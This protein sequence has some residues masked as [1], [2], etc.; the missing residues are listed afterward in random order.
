MILTTIRSNMEHV[1]N[2]FLKK[3]KTTDAKTSEVGKNFQTEPFC[4]KIWTL[5]IDYGIKLLIH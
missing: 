4:F 3:M 1:G 5:G 2:Q